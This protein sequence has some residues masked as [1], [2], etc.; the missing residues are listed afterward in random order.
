MSHASGQYPL[1]TK[2]VLMFTSGDGFHI[3]TMRLQLPCDSPGKGLDSVLS[4]LRPQFGFLLSLFSCLGLWRL[5][6]DGLMDFVMLLGQARPG[7]Y[8]G[9][10]TGVCAPFWAYR[11]YLL[12]SYNWLLSCGITFSSAEQGKRLYLLLLPFISV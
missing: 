5:S 9:S 3:W 4:P 7:H 10:P 8:L 1:G 6:L 12:H 2:V 11:P